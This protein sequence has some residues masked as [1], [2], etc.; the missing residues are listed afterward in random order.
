MEKK[1]NE[2]L[3]NFNE[4]PINN[5]VQIFFSFYLC[6]LKRLFKNLCLIL[7]ILFCDGGGWGYVFLFFTTFS[8]PSS[9][10]TSPFYLYSISLSCQIFSPTL[11][12]LIHSKLFPLPPPHNAH[13]CSFVHF[14]F[15]S[16]L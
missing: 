10:N 13:P 8:L 12:H 16:S 14:I 5:T 1:R 7:Q 6:T 4:I 15:F 9:Q 11:T 2:S 3:T